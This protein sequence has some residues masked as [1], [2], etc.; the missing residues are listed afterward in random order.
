M[1][2]N[3]IYRIVYTWNG[4]E[5]TYRRTGSISKAKEYRKALRQGATG[6]PH[7]DAR[8]TTN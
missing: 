1:T 5:K 8:I 7:I 3:T 4:Q 6:I 2:N